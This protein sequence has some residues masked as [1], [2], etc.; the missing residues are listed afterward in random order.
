MR[1]LAVLACRFGHA[2]SGAEAFARRLR[3]ILPSS[4][5]TVPPTWRGVSNC[6]RNRAEP[7][8]IVHCVH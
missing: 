1:F 6:L 2:L 4:R 3:P 7:S 5:V 8:A